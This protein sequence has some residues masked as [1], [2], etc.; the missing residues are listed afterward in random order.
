MM[1]DED[2]EGILL[3]VVYAGGGEDGA[4]AKDCEHR[5]VAANSTC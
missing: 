3:L 1:F 4:R 5:A 2:P